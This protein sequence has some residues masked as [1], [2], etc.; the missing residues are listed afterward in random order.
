MTFPP[1]G[2]QNDTYYQADKVQAY[3]LIRL[4]ANVELIQRRYGNYAAQIAETAQ[5]LGLATAL[6]IIKDTHSLHFGTEENH[7]NGI[8]GDSPPSPNPHSGHA[9][10]L[11]TLE[12]DGFLHTARTHSFMSEPDFDTAVSDWVQTTYYED[13]TTISG[14]KKVNEFRAKVEKKKLQIK[15]GHD[16]L[17]ENAETQAHTGQKLDITDSQ[18]GLRKK[19]KLDGSSHVMSESQEAQIDSDTPQPSNK[20]PALEPVSI[21]LLH[22]FRMPT[23]E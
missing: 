14:P 6:Q 23:D 19:R 18:Q 9:A 1:P 3:N 8:N 15:R 12:E 13:K 21:G 20:C 16:S 11:R 4:G 10:A 5:C 22:A 17:G 2:L 7:V